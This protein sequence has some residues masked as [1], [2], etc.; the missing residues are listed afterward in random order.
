MKNYQLLQEALDKAC[1]RGAF[2]LQESG[3]VIGALKAIYSEA[4]N[5]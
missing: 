1:Q 2:N 3:Y 4:K 5:N